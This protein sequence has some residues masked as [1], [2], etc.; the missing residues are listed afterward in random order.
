MTSDGPKNI[1]FPFFVTYPMLQI[2]E[3]QQRSCLTTISTF[4]SSVL[5]HVLVKFSIVFS[6]KGKTLVHSAICH[7]SFP[8]EKDNAM[9]LIVWIIWRLKIIQLAERE[10]KTDF[11]FF[12]LL[13]VHLMNH[14]HELLRMSV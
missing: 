10:N 1:V 11:F 3:N 12:V 9:D 4:I 7:R 2:E 6:G 5:S 13:C 8:V 14:D